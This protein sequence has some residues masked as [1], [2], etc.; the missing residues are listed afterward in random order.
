MS[1]IGLTARVI[2]KAYQS[3]RLEH[4]PLIYFSMRRLNQNLFIDFLVQTSVA[5]KQARFRVDFLLTA[6]HRHNILSTFLLRSRI[7]VQ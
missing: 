3:L 6:T 2:A 5:L 1:E 7:T 4:T